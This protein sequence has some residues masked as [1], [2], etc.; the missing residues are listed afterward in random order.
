MEESERQQLIAYKQRWEAVAAIERQEEARRSF[1][2]RWMLLNVLYGFAKATGM[3]L[4]NDD[5]EEEVWPRWATLR[6]A[7]LA[8]LDADTVAV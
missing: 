6:Q 3:E 7:H 8:S 4:D 1:H 5:S 2:E